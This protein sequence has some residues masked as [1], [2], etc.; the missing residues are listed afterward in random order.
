VEHFNDWHSDENVN[1]MQGV[2]EIV[3]INVKRF[4]PPRKEIKAIHGASEEGDS[5]PKAPNIEPLLMDIKVRTFVPSC[6]K[7][8]LHGR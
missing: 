3:D 2:Y 8:S 7:L 4:I 6:W 5:T 1:D